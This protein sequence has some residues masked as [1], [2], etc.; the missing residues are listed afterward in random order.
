MTEKLFYVNP[1]QKEFTAVVIDCRLGEKGYE[2]SLDR[3]IFYSEGGGQPWDMGII[4]KSHVIEVQEKNGEI[5]HYMDQP[6]EVGKTV[7]GVIDWERRFDFMQQ[8]SGE[9]I[10][11]GIINRRFGYNNVGFHMGAEVV[12]IDFDGEITKEQML[13]VEQEAN[14][15]VWMN[16]QC[17]IS[18]PEEEALHSIPYRSKKELSGMVRIVTFPGSDICACCGLHV[19]KS[20]EIGMVKLLSVQKFRQG[21]RMEMICGKRV[22]NYM[23]LLQSQNEQISVLLSA[24]PE[25]VAA[26]VQRL[27][28]ENFHLKGQLMEIEGREL[29]M[30][31]QQMQGKGNVLLFRENLAP[32]SIRKLAVAGMECC[33]GICAVF[34]AVGEDSMRYAIGKKDGDLRELVKK[35]NSQ[36]NG[37]GG[38][39]PFFVQGSVNAKEETIRRFFKETCQIDSFSL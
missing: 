37:R 27:F 21:V 14:A 25:K 3:T 1:Y 30:T 6:L 33:G 35:L 19:N 11:S 39:K 22:L 32:D 2:V 36:L 5:V 18:F 8:H 13:E 34:S 38:G 31:A 20:G 23:N 17:E 26:S 16:V 4:E 29:R 7:Q 24:K 15:Q 9:H 10:V 28:E 12:T